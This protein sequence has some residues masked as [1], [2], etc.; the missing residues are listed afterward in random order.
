M[1]G[2]MKKFLHERGLTAVQVAERAGLPV[3]S[4]IWR[5]LS[6]ERKMHPA[7]KETLCRIYGMTEAE[8]KEAAPCKR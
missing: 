7:F 8:W 6:G 1:T 5:M 2:A 3:P 4:D